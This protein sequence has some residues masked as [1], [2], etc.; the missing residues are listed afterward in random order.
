MSAKRTIGIVLAV[1]LAYVVIKGVINAPTPAPTT[2]PA[3]NNN[4]YSVAES[5]AKR[6]READRIVALEAFTA[7]EIAAAYSRNT[8]SADMNFKGQQFR[9]S[10]TVVNINTDFRGKP[11]VTMKGG[12]N[13]FMEPQFTLASSDER[14]AVSLQP[15]SKVT[16][17]C[18]GRG[19]VAKTPMADDCT[20]VW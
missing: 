19:D 4:L 11:Y 17:A 12:V 13:R 1:G 9:V 14:F 8:V 16:L 18:T 3:A 10:G 6:Q 2:Q 5:N 20:F 7:E 15:G